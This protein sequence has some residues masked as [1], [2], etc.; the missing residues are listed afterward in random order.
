MANNCYG[1]VDLQGER[2]QEALDY[3]MSIANDNEGIQVVANAEDGY[4]FDIYECDGTLYFWT[5]WGPESNQV[6]ALADMFG[7]GFTYMY[8]ESGNQIY[9]ECR[10]TPGGEMVDYY[11]PDEIL[12]EAVFNWDDDYYSWRGKDYECQSEM[13]D[14]MLEYVIEQAQ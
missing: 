3:I 10:Y 2:K 11:I 5:K 14:A 4:L 1:F 7:L 13:M 12:E 9:G 6:K 8:E